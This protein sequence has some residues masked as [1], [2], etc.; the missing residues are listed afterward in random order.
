MPIFL[1]D[2]PS[3]TIREIRQAGD[4]TP[5][6][7]D[8]LELYLDGMTWWNDANNSSYTFPLRLQGNQFRRLGEQ[9][10]QQYTTTELFLQNQ[11]PLNWRIQFA[12]YSHEVIFRGAN[13]FREDRNEEIYDLSNLSA[14]TR[15]AIENQFSDINT[16]AIEATTGATGLTNAQINQIAD[17]VAERAAP[18][19]WS[20]PEREL[21][22]VP[23][24]AATAATLQNTYTLLAEI[25]QK[26]EE[27]DI[28]L[29]AIE[30]NRIASAVWANQDR[31]V[32]LAAGQTL[33]LVGAVWSAAQRDLTGH[34][35]AILNAIAGAVWAADGRELTGGEGATAIQATNILD[36][37][38]ALQALI[39]EVH[40]LLGYRAGAPITAV[41][42]GDTGYSEAGGI[43]LDRT[44]T[45]DA[46][47]KIT[48]VQE[49]RS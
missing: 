41:K 11:P 20:H 44:Q 23:P 1:Y 46:T 32:Q 31:T 29:N 42:D 35:E 10:E 30:L 26:V 5:V 19:I 12:D 9:G 16:L 22:D 21:T 40:L 24:N 38:A 39:D 27:G 3:R 18:G 8:L 25:G 34:P 37:L 28:T 15:V 17:L 45:I 2:G 49:R 43:R 7:Y 6:T 13:L 14:G 47:G 36:D 48:V 4:P 33:A